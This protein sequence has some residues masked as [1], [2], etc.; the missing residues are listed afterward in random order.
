M[1]QVLDVD[2]SLRSQSK[3][4]FGGAVADHIQ[5]PV[6]QVVWRVN[7][8]RVTGMDPGAFHMFHNAGDQYI[9]AVGNDV[10]FQFGARQILV[11]QDRIFD[12]VFKDPCHIR[13]HR[14]I[15]A[16]NG[17]VLS[18]DDVGWTQQDR[19]AQ[20]IGCGKG[21]FNGERGKSPRSFDAE[22]F[23]QSVKTDTVFRKV[24]SV[25]RGAE[26]AH[27]AAVQVFG[28]FDGCLPPECNHNP[29]GLLCLKDL[30]DIFIIQ[31]FKIKAVGGI[32][33]GRNRLRVVVDDDDIV[34]Q[35]PQCPDAMDRAVIEFN[36]LP[37]TD[38][39]GAKDDDHRFPAAFELAGF[40]DL[41][42]GGIEIR[43]CCVKFGSAG[44]D[45]LVAHGEFWQV[46]A[47]AQP[48][49]SIVGI[50]KTFAERIILIGKSC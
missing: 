2:Q 3:C 24:D 39:T 7:G 19:V 34:A 9:R 50:A 6:I 29:F 22:L 28:E 49:Q 45:H 4:E 44:V 11:D 30:F 46:D 12:L 1:D 35:F 5:H 25:R 47:A 31:W 32:V 42:A 14:F 23:Q 15:R 38:R 18:A 20:G 8:N 43:R 21:F 33:I 41:I 27:A 36:T 48:F 26:D 13:L 10:H 40:T 16:G 17:H 37:D